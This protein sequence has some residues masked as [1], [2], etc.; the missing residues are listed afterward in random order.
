M[1]I[2]R[3]GVF[4]SVV[5]LASVRLLHRTSPADRLDGPP[6]FKCAISYETAL[7]LAKQLNI[8]LNDLLWDPV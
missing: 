7:L 1:E 8:S 6:Q 3:V 4:S 2:S 5:E